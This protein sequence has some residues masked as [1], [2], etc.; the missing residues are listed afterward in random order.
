MNGA[1]TQLGIKSLGT[2]SGAIDLR[3]EV[4]NDSLKFFVNGAWAVSANDSVLTTGSVG[5]R[6]TQ[7]AV[8]SGS[9]NFTAAVRLPLV[10]PATPLSFSDNFSTSNYNGATNTLTTTGNGLGLAW[11]EMVGAY[12]V[13]S[14]LATGAGGLNLAIINTVQADVMLTANVTIPVMQYFGLTARYSGPGDTNMYWGAVGNVGGS[15][16]AYIFKHVNGTWTQ[17]ATQSLSSFAGLI[18]FSVIGSTLTLKL[19]GVYYAALD[20]TDNSIST[21]KAGIRS[22]AGTTVA[23]FT[24]N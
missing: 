11:K 9:P 5:L 23:S 21:G 22:T 18:E 3:F 16:V 1:W 15:Y 7:G 20:R 2:L 17:L 6:S 12:T 14:G 13:G 24:A 19:D 8:W 10:A 4:I